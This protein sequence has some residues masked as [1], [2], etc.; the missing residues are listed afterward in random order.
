MRISFAEPAPFD[1]GKFIACGA[2][3]NHISRL[4]VRKTLREEFGCDHFIYSTLFDAAN[5]RQVFIID[6]YKKHA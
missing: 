3:V 2:A 6:G 5:R 4:Q 1:G